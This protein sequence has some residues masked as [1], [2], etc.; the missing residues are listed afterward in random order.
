[1]AESGSWPSI[2][3]HGL[4]STAALLDFYNIPQADRVT[5]ESQWRRKSI[6][7]SS[8]Q[9]GSAVIRDQI[10]MP[11]H[12]LHLSVK[13]MSVEEWYRLI[14]SKVFFWVTGDRL[15]QLLCASQ[16]RSRSHTVLTVDTKTLVQRYLQKIHL[17]AVN[18]G[19]T[20]FSNPER[21]SSTFKPIGVFGSNIIVELTVEHS[22]PDISDF[23]ISVEERQQTKRLQ[24]IW[25]RNQ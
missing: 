9:H 12:K 14:N 19:S 8:T 21:G 18:S 22:I 1:M 2:Q 5:I 24:V 23:V 3:Q 4:L 15:N 7:I 20:Y 17:S 25:Q 11:P 6:T 13:D 10:P 16:Y